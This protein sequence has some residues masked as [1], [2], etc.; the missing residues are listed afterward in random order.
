MALITNTS[1]Y[2]F[3]LQYVLDHIFVLYFSNCCPDNKHTVLPPL[4]LQPLEIRNKIEFSF[5]TLDE[6]KTTL[7]RSSNFESEIPPRST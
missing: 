1:T 5:I 6:L 3:G 7:H 4:T 2:L